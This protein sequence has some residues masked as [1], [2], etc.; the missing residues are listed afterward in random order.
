M[1]D[2]HHDENK[3]LASHAKKGRRKIRS[4]SKAFNEK[5]T[6]AAPV[7]EKRKDISKI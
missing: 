3:S 7:H 1:Q 2:S 5:K 6:S 4:F